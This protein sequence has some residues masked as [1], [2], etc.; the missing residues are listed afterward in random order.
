[1][2]KHVNILK[3]E[4]EMAEKWGRDLAEFGETLFYMQ[5]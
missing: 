2:S 1:M 5:C 4:S 3:T